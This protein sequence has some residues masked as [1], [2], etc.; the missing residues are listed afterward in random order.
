MAQ[1][2]L[3]YEQCDLV[4]GGDDWANVLVEWFR[5]HGVPDDVTH[6]L[7]AQGSLYRPFVRYQPDPTCSTPVT[8]STGG[9]RWPRR[10]T[11]TGS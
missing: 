11:R 6:E 8:R 3:D 2:R 1:G 4:W 9:A 7:I 10:G 5:G